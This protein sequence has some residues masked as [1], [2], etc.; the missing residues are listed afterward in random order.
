[1]TYVMALLAGLMFGLGLLLSG[2]GNPAV[3][4]GFLDPFGHWNPSLGL[5]MVGALSVAGLGVFLAKRR[6]HAG[7]GT[8]LV[9][10]VGGK[11]DGRLV[12]GGVL[13]GVGW[14][15]VGIC[16][17]PAM[18]LLSRGLWQGWVFAVALFAGMG[19]FHFINHSRSRS[20]R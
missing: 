17:G 10:P 14:G 12:L 20:C 19:L 7:N 8:A 5:V 15:L 13:F 6:R 1:M 11:I 2:M 9:L 18:L 4:Q 16:P 3:V